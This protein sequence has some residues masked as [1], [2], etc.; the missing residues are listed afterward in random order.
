MEESANLKINQLE[1]LFV[2][3]KNIFFF[4]LK[5]EQSKSVTHHQP[6]QHMYNRSPRVEKKICQKKIFE[7]VTAENLP[8]LM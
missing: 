5:N 8:N 7:E 3:G 6:Y 4:F 1:F 2:T